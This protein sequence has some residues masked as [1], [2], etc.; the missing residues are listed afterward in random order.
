MKPVT[1]HSSRGF[2]LVEVLVVMALLSLI[3]LG[4]GSALRTTAQT[5][6]RIDARLLQTDELRIASGFL[7]S[8]MGRTYLQ[9][10]NEPSTVGQ[11]P[12]FF[13]GSPTT[14]TWIGIMPAR[15]GVGGRY[16]FR[17]AL[18]QSEGQSGVVLSFV[19]WVGEVA[20]PDWSQA[21]NRL[22]VPGA[23]ALALRYTNT[24]LEP[25]Q[26]GGGWNHPELL[27]DRVAITVG[28]QAGEWP[29]LVIPMRSTPRGARGSGG[30]AVFGG[31]RS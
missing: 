6:E 31:G 17:L 23:T 20:V 3:V 2:T 25:V 12:Y 22:L 29:M 14:L 1:T 4:M 10:P 30:D 18:G 13:E 24:N 5:G 27:P 15:H 16:Y 28:T 11:A 8:A 19:P 21:Q 7:R 9:R 26:W